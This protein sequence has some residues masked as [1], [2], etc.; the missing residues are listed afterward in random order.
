M[1]MEGGQRL[2]P[3]EYRHHW[4]TGLRKFRD[5]AHIVLPIQQLPTLTDLEQAF[6]GVSPGKAVGLDDIPPELCHHQPISMA[7]C[8]NA[9]ML[10]AALIGQEAFDHKGGKLAIAWKQKEDVLDCHTP[11][12]GHYLF[13]V[14]WGK[15]C[16]GLS[17]RS[18]IS[19]TMPICKGNRWEEDPRCQW[20]SLSILAVHIFAGNNA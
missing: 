15:Q 8:S 5:E 16:A 11:H 12:T 6:R 20:P 4:L 17:N 19:C 1:H 10:N 18:T 2:S 13:Q 3:A 7:R 14:M 9:I